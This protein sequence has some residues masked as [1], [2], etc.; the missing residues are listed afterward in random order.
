MSDAAP[1]EFAG[2]DEELERLLLGFARAVGGWAA[3]D[4]RRGGWIVGAGSLLSLN[5]NTLRWRLSVR[6]QDGALNVDGPRR[7]GF[8]KT[9]RLADFRRDQLRD[10]LRG[11]TAGDLRRPFAAF[12]GDAAGI[13]AGV[14]WS[15]ASVVAALFVAAIVATLASFPVL[16][17]AIA[18]VLD[19]ARALEA[20]GAVALPNPAR[21]PCLDCSAFVFA[22]PIAFLAGMLHWAALLL[23]ELWTRA[24]RL[25]QASFL[26]LTALLTLAFLPFTPVLALP[27]A[28][29]VPLSVH[30]ACALVW[31]FRR[32]RTADGRPPRKGAAILATVA[33]LAALAALTPRPAEGR[34]FTDRLALF[35]DRF[36][37]QNGI[38][39]FAAT[40]YYR[41]TLAS[42]DPLLK[43]FY[44]LDESATPT[45][46][47]RTVRTDDPATAAAFRAIH[48][49]VVPA[50]S[51][52]DVRV[53]GRTLLAGS[54][55]VAWD[56]DAASLGRTVDRL[57]Q[58]AYRG[59]RLRDLYW[60]AWRSIYHGGPVLV[61]LVLAAPFAMLL[62]VLLR[63]L[64]PRAALVAMGFTFA[65]SVTLLATSLSEEPKGWNDLQALRSGPGPEAVGI[66]LA[67]AS[68]GVRHEA[69]VRA[70]LHPD[71]SFAGALLKT[72]DDPD[73]RV[74]L[75]SVAALGATKSPD[76]L[77]KL[78][79]RLK[80]PELFVRYRAA[81]GLG[82]L[83]RKEAVDPLLRMTREG[84]WYEG[85]YALEALRRID[86][87]R[88]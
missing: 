22:A 85:L 88:F 23:G 53:D 38:G 47:V 43:Q 5:P 6:R 33:T 82:L 49:S 17:W 69:A 37:L 27:L 25:P 63:F 36:M 31:A 2:T 21:P 65:V 40:T 8:A 4:P 76:A 18:D 75:W 41:H 77:P 39:K 55:S 64:K 29:A 86:P 62:S 58:D 7:R 84:I 60:L 12:G 78:L 1:L 3:R 79:E 14:A 57:A 71:P 35:R 59:A 28:A 10:F 26:F 61:L 72:S 32:E 80:D 20:A 42:A 15:A 46:L 68:A 50:G 9:R 16:Q 44:A 67:S 48:F 83:G 73:V 45:R 74:R 51:A 56:G 34:E 70:F 54:R 52:A 24:E 81:E 19:R 30:A 13:A 66:A 11:R 87:A